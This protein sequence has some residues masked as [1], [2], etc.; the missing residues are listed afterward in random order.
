MA[1]INFRN[2]TIREA[3]LGIKDGAGVFLNVHFAA[4]LSQPIMDEMEWESPAECFENPVKLAGELSGHKLILTPT[5]KALKQ[6]EIDI[7]CGEIGEFKFF[8]IKANESR[9]ASSEIRFC[10][11]VSEVGAVAKVENYLRLMGQNPAAMKVTYAVQEKLDLGVSNGA[12]QSEVSSKCPGCRSGIQLMHNDD[13]VH[14]D[15]SKCLE[16][17]ASEGKGDASPAQLDVLASAAQM[18]G[19]HQKKSRKAPAEGVQ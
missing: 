14:V 5:D 8:R 7:E 15:G 12:E 16:W 10:A 9:S 18:G 17:E 2:A 11:N 19:T 1:T 4:D 6:H 3:H 13:G